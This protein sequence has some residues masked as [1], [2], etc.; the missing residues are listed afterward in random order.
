[1]IKWL[2][3]LVAHF[4]PYCTEWVDDPPDEPRPRTVYVVGGR[5][6]PFY[7]VVACPRRACPQVVNLDVSPEVKPRWR[8]KEH[9]D[10]TLSLH[11]S[12]RVTGLPCKCHYWLRR[13][14]VVWSEAPKVF[15]PR[16]NRAASEARP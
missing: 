15:V 3:N 9:T 5:R 7:T 13:G 12:I 14:R 6:H 4:R 2:A 16:R 11:P 1:M 10:G 8:I